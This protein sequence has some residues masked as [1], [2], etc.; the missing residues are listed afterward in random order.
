VVHSLYSNA[1]PKTFVIRG[2]AGLS[3]AQ[4][5]YGQSTGDFSNALPKGHAGQRADSGAAII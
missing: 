5:R 1:K 4:E 3:V 2:G